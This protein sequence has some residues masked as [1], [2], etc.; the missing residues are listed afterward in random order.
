M[1]ITGLAQWNAFWL[2]KFTGFWSVRYTNII[3]E[4]TGRI[5]AMTVFGILIGYG[6]VL[7]TIAQK[8]QARKGFSSIGVK[9][10]GMLSII[11]GFLIS[12]GYSPD[13]EA[14]FTAQKAHITTALDSPSRGSLVT[15]PVP[16]VSAYIFP[17]AE[18]CKACHPREY[19]EWKKSYHSQSIHTAT[20]RAMYTIN[21]YET[22]GKR[23]EY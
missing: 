12:S 3:H 6:I 9:T 5:F 2:M 11:I 21:D 22:E 7:R 18:S 15:S 20:F 13:A 8:I 23:P 17:S 10:A 1:V 19:Q 4:W 14:S 16:G